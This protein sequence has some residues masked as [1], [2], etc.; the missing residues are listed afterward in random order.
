MILSYLST[1]NAQIGFFLYI[2]NEKSRDFQ[3]GETRFL[4]P[5][6]H[7]VLFPGLVTLDQSGDALY[8]IFILRYN[9]L[10]CC[11][12]HKVREILTMII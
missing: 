1:S 3:R 8:R 4:F 5:G 2:W 6:R 9:K 10:C 11:A 7:D 12:D